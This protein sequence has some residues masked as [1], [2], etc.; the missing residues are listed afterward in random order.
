MSCL[1]SCQEKWNVINTHTHTHTACYVQERDLRHPLSR[2]LASGGKNAAWLISFPDIFNVCTLSPQAEAG[3]GEKIK[4]RA[5]LLP[6]LLQVMLKRSGQ[7]IL[8]WANGFAYMLKG[9]PHTR[10]VASSFSF[11]FLFFLA[12]KKPF[13]Y[14]QLLLHCSWIS[15]T[16]LKERI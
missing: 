1:F 12:P 10:Q 3:S 11:S 2:R 15:A 6:A 13:L 16:V 9:F 7:L 4:C 14:R 8:Q 5:F